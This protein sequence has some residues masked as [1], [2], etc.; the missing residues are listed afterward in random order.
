MSEAIVRYSPR[1]RARAIKSFLSK[2]LGHGGAWLGLLCL[3]FFLVLAA[4]PNILVGPLETVATATGDFLDPPSSQHFLGTDEVGRDVLNL[5][6]HGAR[7][8]LTIALLATVISLVVGTTVGMTAGYY[9]GWVDVW[10]MRLTDFFFV[11][12][13][14]VL[15]LVI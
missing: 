15:A 2:F 6:V 12:P 13:S 10:L 5:V 4:V 11:M 8:S 3:G 1:I 9:D 14:F 7:I